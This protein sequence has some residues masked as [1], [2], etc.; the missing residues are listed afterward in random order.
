[1]NYKLQARILKALAHESRLKIIDRLSKGE[2]SVGELVQV[3][4]GDRT[5]VSKHLAILRSHGIIADRREGNVVYCSL[6]TP[7]VVG[8]LSCAASVLKEREKGLSEG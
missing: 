2:C 5:T 3:V 8:F 6:V 4:G 1:M 7:C